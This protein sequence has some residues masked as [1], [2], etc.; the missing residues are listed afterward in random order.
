MGA[1][2]DERDGLVRVEGDLAVLVHGGV[3]R[4]HLAFALEHLDAAHGDDGGGP[5]DHDR[6]TEFLGRREAP[7]VRIGSE[8]RELALEGDDFRERGGA[9]RVGDVTALGGFH[10]VAAAPE[11]V[12]GVV[13]GDRAHAVLVGE[14]DAAFDG[15]DGDGLA[16]FLVGVPDF[17]RLEARGLLRDSRVGRAARDL[18]AGTKQFVEVQRLEGV[19]GADAVVRGHAGHLGGLGRLLRAEAALDVGGG[20]ERLVGGAGD[21]VKNF[22][23]GRMAA[24]SVRRLSSPGPQG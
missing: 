22:A 6:E 10:H 12:E 9:V 15:V 20:D 19:V 8:R 23:H 5:V 13:D 11:V 16:K 1:E 21:D 14:L 18:G 3:R 17:G 2:W 7:R 24:G 4:E